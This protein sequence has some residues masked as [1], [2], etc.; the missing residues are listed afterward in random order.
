MLSKP[1]RPRISNRQQAI[2]KFLKAPKLLLKPQFQKIQIQ[3]SENDRENFPNGY[4]IFLI[5]N[6]FHLNILKI[7]N[8]SA[9]AIRPSNNNI[10]AIWAY[11]ITFSFGLR[12]VTI[13]MIVNN[14]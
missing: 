10:P 2:G 13:S 14:A 7:S 4:L 8:P 9:Y 6:S 3:I 1:R 5:P 11:S 12:R